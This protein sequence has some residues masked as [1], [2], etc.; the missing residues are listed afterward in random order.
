MLRSN[1]SWWN[2]TSEED[3]GWQGSGKFGKLRFR[4]SHR[5]DTEEDLIRAAIERLPKYDRLRKGMLRKVADNGKVVVDE[6]DVTKLGTQHKRQLMDSIL[7][8][9]EEDNENFL[10]K[11]RDRTDRYTATFLD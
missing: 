1:R 11:L 4:R 9:V 8:V 3:G 6:V 2:E 10:R 5:Y 7:K